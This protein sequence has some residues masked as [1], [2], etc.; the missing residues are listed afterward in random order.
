[1]VELPNIGP[2][3]ATLYLGKVTEVF[4][5]TSC[6]LEMAF[7]RSVWGVLLPPNYHMRVKAL[8]RTDLENDSCEMV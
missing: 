3:V 4:P 5:L 7:K 2:F 6:G 8:H 1:M